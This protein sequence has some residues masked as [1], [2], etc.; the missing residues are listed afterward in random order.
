ML[1]AYMYTSTA[2]QEMEMDPTLDGGNFPSFFTGWHW[3]AGAKRHSTARNRPHHTSLILERVE[4]IMVLYSSSHGSKENKR[5]Y[6]LQGLESRW[7]VSACRR[8]IRVKQRPGWEKQFFFWGG[9]GFWGKL[10]RLLSKTATCRGSELRFDVRSR[11]TN[12]V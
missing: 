5:K 1:D 3:N 12:P 10:K 6:Q 7:R 11:V 2:A 4:S 8:F 9:K